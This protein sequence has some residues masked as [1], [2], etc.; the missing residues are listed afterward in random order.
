[1]TARRYLDIL[2]DT[3]L[4]RQLQPFHTNAKKRTIK[5]P[6]V[7]IRDSGLLHALLRIR[8]F[9]DLQGHPVVGSSWEG[10]VIEQIVNVLPKGSE[11]YFYRTGAGAE[12]DLLF[13]AGRAS[14]VAVEVKYSLNPGISKGFRIASKDL[15]C[16][17]SFVV[18][19]GDESYPLG[20]GAYSL[21]MSKLHML[22]K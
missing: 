3:F 11:T 5:S 21:P 19:P 2:E 14:P 16:N 4:V 17:K 9:D 18:Y 22:L 10:F 8:S 12:L 1:M 6:K 13:F 7:Y 20:N 15:S